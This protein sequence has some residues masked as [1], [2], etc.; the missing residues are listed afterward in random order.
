M[1]DQPIEVSRRARTEK[2]IALVDLAGRLAAL[3]NNG[4]SV[5]IGGLF[6]QG[7][8]TALVRELIRSGLS[9]LKLF[10]SPG[11]GYDVDLLVASGIV[12]E[13]FLP[14]VTL[15][16]RFCPSFRSAV[17]RGAIKAH[18]VDALTIIG[19]L[20]AAAHNVPYQPVTGWAGSDV[21]KFNPLIKPVESPFGSERVWAV[22]AI[23]PDFV[24]LH[25]Q[26]GDVYGN[27][28]HL[29]TMTYADE[30]MVRAGKKVFVS[31]DKLIPHEAILRDPRA[32]TVPGI[33]V[34]AIVEAP[35]GAH[36]SASYP[37]YG[38]DEVF[39]EQFA[40]L[41]DY[42]RKTGD[43]RPIADYIH[44]YVRD[45]KDIFDYIDAVGGY[46]KIFSL[47]REARFI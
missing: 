1:I 32:T 42:V 38:M 34:E 33:Y 20:L 21:L 40:D 6:K 8:P 47:E 31:V 35:F 10:S 43:A 17:E 28:C 26:E 14:A 9:D 11:S 23:R 27:A 4:C 7:R 22:P 37:N 13:A 29:S 3:G 2:V 44:K 19:G 16:N 36:P 46:R 5:C 15:E 12:S 41:G 30:L 24:L 25:A 18:V 45:P 39:I